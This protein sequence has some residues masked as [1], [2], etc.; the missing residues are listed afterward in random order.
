MNLLT[1]L[2]T[3]SWRRTRSRIFGHNSRS[4]ADSTFRNPHTSGLDLR[5]SVRP[6]VCPACVWRGVDLVNCAAYT[7]NDPKYSR[8]YRT[9]TVTAPS[10]TSCNS[11]SPITDERKCADCLCV[12][13]CPCKQDHNSK[14]LLWT[15]LNTAGWFYVGMVWYSRV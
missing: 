6:S 4:D 10:C 12:G 5:P 3:Y 1:Y 14:T 13:L 7:S 2:L 9:P 15:D 8:A 11:L